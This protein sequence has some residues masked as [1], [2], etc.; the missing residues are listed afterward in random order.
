MLKAFKNQLKQMSMDP[1]DS[2]AELLRRRVGASKVSQHEQPLRNM[3][4]VMPDMLA[5]IKAWIEEPG[6]SADLRRLQGFVLTYL[7][8]PKD[9][10]PEDSNGLFGYI[11]DAFLVSL[12]FQRTLAERRGLGYDSSLERELAGQLP[13][14]LKHAREVIP[15]EA[16]QVVLMFNELITGKTRLYEEVMGGDRT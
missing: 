10:L 7:Y 11:D 13:D 9:I 5:Q 14:W 12:A 8:H 4:L 3:I 15:R 16:E 2:F 1:A 6:M